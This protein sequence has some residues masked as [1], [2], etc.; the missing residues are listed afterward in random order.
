MIKTITFSPARIFG[1]EERLGSLGAGKDADIL[2]FRREA[3]R[4]WPLL[5]KVMVEGRIVYEQE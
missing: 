4:P 1:V 5:K 3:G 2:F